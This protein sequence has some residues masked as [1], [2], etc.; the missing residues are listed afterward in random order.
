MLSVPDEAHL[1][2]PQAGVL[3]APLEAGENMYIDLQKRYYARE[4]Y[5]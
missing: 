2:H 5:I 1:T 4:K 3:G